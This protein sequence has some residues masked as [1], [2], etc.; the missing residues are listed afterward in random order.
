MCSVVYNSKFTDY[1]S[2]LLPFPLEGLDS[3]L[4]FIC[5]LYKRSEVKFSLSTPQRH[6][7]EV[8]V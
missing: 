6:M 2:N 3:R 1:L 7:G 4:F 5:S 8:E